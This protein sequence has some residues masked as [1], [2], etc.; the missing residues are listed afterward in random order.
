MK[1]QT[2]ERLREIKFVASGH[3]PFAETNFQY[4]KSD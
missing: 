4:S 1:N 3:I 2:I